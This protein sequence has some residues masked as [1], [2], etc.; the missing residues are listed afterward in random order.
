MVAVSFG[1][2]I[3]PA[4]GYLPYPEMQN[5]YAERGDAAQLLSDVP[6]PSASRAPL[7][8]KQAITDGGAV[9]G[10]VALGAWLLV[11]IRRKYV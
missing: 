3:V 1:I 7:T 9:G 10:F 5:A 8:R 11:R 6:P 4:A 2:G